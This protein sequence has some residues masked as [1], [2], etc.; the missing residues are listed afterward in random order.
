MTL[1][2]H[3]RET[4]IYL[5]ETA[6]SNGHAPATLTCL[7]ATSIDLAVLATESDRALA[8]WTCRA[9]AVTLS[10]HGPRANESGRNGAAENEN[11]REERQ[12][13]DQLADYGSRGPSGPLRRNGSRYRYLSHVLR[14]WVC[15]LTFTE[16]R[17]TRPPGTLGPFDSYPGAQ[18]GNAV[19]VAHGV[20]C[21]T[22][23][24]VL[25]EAVACRARQNELEN[26]GGCG[27]AP[28]FTSQRVSLPYL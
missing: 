14:Q 10:D 1:S 8:T 23:I 12:S 20:L 27:Y 17:L 18:D 4:S 16:E 13:G 19:Q 2:G 11:D 9:A 5:A 28:L 3:V 26:R 25:D 21:V 15:T 22:P 24:L 6:T 7:V